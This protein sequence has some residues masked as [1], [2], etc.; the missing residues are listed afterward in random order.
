MTEELKPC[1]FCGGEAE[2]VTWPKPHQPVCYVK[3]KNCLAENCDDDFEENVAL[4][5][6]SWNAR[7]PDPRVKRLEEA[8]WGVFEDIGYNAGSAIVTSASV[9]RLMD[10][11]NA[12]SEEGKA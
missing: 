8:A 12:L 7:A 4:N 5:V 9:D 10:A 6:F 2:I 3:C 11:L 1:P